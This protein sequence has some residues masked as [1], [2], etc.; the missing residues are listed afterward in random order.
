MDGRSS[1][2]TVKVGPAIVI[3][4]GARVG[5]RIDNVRRPCRASAR[6]S[7]GD[8][9]D[10]LSLLTAVQ[11]HALLLM[12]LDAPPPPVVGKDCNR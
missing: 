8:V 6:T 2:L 5:R 11:S 1:L 12:T 9:E 4:P 7:T 10:K 3:V